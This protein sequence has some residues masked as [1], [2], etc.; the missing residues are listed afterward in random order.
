[1]NIPYCR[2]VLHADDRYGLDQCQTCD[3]AWE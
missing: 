3:T 1:M 2:Y